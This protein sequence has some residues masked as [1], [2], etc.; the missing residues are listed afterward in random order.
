MKNPK[1]FY[2][3]LVVTCNVL[4]IKLSAGRVGRIKDSNANYGAVIFSTLHQEK[5]LKRNLSLTD[6]ISFNTTEKCFH[7]KNLPPESKT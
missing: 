7:T 3:F 5:N 6:F 1:L 2:L 4:T